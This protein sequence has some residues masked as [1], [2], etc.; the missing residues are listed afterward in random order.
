MKYFKNSKFLVIH[1]W[2]LLDDFR[3]TEKELKNSVLNS[4]IKCDI[5]NITFGKKSKYTW[6]L[7]SSKHTKKEQMIT[8]KSKKSKKEQKIIYI[9]MN[10]KKNKQK[11]AFF[12]FITIYAY[13]IKIYKISLFQLCNLKFGKIFPIW[14]KINVHFL[15]SRSLKGIW[16]MQILCF[17]LLIPYIIIILK[18]LRIF[19][20]KILK[21]K[22]KK[23]FR[24]FFC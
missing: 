5:S 10:L 12:Y 24:A 6:H 11:I 20:K 13:K 21:K 1:I 8:K 18:I 19:E 15:I 4:N 23:G 9:K 22:Q 7:L 2:W 14:T 16:K 17:L 3:M